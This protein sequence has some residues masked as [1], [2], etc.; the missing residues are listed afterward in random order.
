MQQIHDLPTSMQPIVKDVI[1]TV[2]SALQYTQVTVIVVKI[3]AYRLYL[4][5]CCISGIDHTRSLLNKEVDVHSF[6]RQS[7][8]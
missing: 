4:L 1:F 3:Q 5:L 6:C 7:C 2:I 8:E